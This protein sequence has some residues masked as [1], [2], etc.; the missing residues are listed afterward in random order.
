MNTCGEEG[1]DVSIWEHSH[2]D[3]TCNILRHTVDFTNEKY[4]PMLRQHQSGVLSIL[5]DIAIG[6][7]RLSDKGTLELEMAHYARFTKESKE[8][9]RSR[10]IRKKEGD[11][12]V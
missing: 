11:E 3:P 2:F 5:H 7:R 9:D 4:F 1:K 8:R 6:K 12:K 10:K